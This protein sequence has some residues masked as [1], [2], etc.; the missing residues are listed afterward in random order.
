M[1]GKRI[2]LKCNCVITRCWG[3]RILKDKYCK[4]CSK[5]RIINLRKIWELN[6]K[7]LRISYHKKYYEKNK[8][9]ILEKAIIYKR[10]KG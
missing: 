7:P 8:S 9:K 4:A 3:N 2:C 10:K 5:E 1:K 6:N